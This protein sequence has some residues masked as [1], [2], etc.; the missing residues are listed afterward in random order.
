MF[1]LF[2][3]LFCHEVM[4]PDA[5]ILVFWKL[6]FTP[7]FSLSSFNFIKRLFS[8]SSLSAI[9]VMSSE[10]LRLLILLLAILIPAYASFSWAFLIMYFAYK[11]NKQCDNIQP[12]STPFPTWNQSVVPCPILIIAPWPA[13]KFLNRQVSWSG[14][15]ISFRIFHG[16]LWST[17]AK[18]LA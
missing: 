1:P 10:Y 11:L 18:A 14:I 6:S 17:Q 9:R 15:P 12:W 16:L 8:S 13:Y 3:H 4:R 7:S 2:P 5:M